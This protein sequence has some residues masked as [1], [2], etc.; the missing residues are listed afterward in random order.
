MN[1]W[2]K[3]DSDILQ[4]LYSVCKKIR[5][6]LFPFLLV[7]LYKQRHISSSVLLKL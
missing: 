4:P 6:I 5:T 2:G 1:E 3:N 7:N